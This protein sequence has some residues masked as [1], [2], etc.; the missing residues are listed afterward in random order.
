MF[1]SVPFSP[2]FFFFPPAQTAFLPRCT[3]K[4][5]AAELHGVL[6]N[7]QFLVGADMLHYACLPKCP[8]HYLPF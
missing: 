5:S 2:F 7:W 8:L 3:W 4:L 1:C 6:V